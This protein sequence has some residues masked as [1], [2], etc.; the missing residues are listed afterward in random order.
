MS[1]WT[2]AGLRLG[3]CLAAALQADDGL[4]R[5]AAVDAAGMGAELTRLADE[6]PEW[7]RLESLG[8]SAEGRE[9]W[10]VRL[11]RGAGT[12]EFDERPG[13]WIVDAC[14]A[15]N[16]LGSSAAMELVRY[17]LSQRASDPD[18]GAALERVALYVSPAL[19]PDRLERL[20]GAPAD[21]NE[22]SAELGIRF[23]RNFPSGWAPESLREQSGPF[24][25]FR[26]EC[27]AVVNFLIERSNLAV[28]H[29]LGTGDFAR[30]SDF[31]SVRRGHAEA[32]RRPDDSQPEEA[33]GGGL[34]A[35][36]R[37]ER[38]LHT[39]SAGLRIDA[40]ET[41]GPQTPARR[42]L[43]LARGYVALALELPSLAVEFDSVL[44][45]EEGLW[46]VDVRVSNEA[47]LALLGRGPG[48]LKVS[49]G[50]A[51]VLAVARRDAADEPYRLLAKTE[52]DLELEALGGHG[53][54]WL[55]FVVSGEPGANL[56][57]E[58][59]PRRGGG[60]ASVGVALP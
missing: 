45:L 33:E 32:V 17:A 31:D 5:P 3:L 2:I 39:T 28:V 10:L 13:L 19:D 52:P 18:V 8:Q 36:A 7:M 60:A 50:G 58:A 59:A 54:V 25:L 30:L 56:S 21:P 4:P 20:S 41:E 48:G 53:Q 27:R 38:G 22:P 49:L 51:Q 23:D 46:A 47:S 44:E 37:V 34:L 1:L 24:P 9:L 6:N 57:I 15:D 11:G 14:G 16:G 55:R 12:P 35:F 29:A 43:A 40:N 26:P 42:Y